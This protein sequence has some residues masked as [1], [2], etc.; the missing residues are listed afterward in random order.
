[1]DK[2]ERVIG[3]SDFDKLV[4]TVKE[5]KVKTVKMSRFKEVDALNHKAGEEI[6]EEVE[7]TEVEKRKKANFRK[8][9]TIKMMEKFK[10]SLDTLV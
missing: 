6:D 10:Q 4:P 7:L 1:M 9:A 8:P 5:M 3:L 2:K